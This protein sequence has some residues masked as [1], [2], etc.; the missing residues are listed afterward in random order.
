MGPRKCEVCNE[1]L[2]KYKCPSCLVPYCSLVC[3]KKHKEIPCAKPVSSE[4]KPRISGLPLMSQVTGDLSPVLESLVERPLTAE[5][6]GDVLQKL[7]LEAIASSSEI[8]DALKDGN[9]QK[10]IYNIDGSPDAE[11]ELDKAMGVEVFRTFTEKI[12]SAASAS[13]QL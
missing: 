9:L 12:L 3:F 2:S 13:S 1:A 5:Q 6:P 7:Q 10:L 8:R 11:N 4:G